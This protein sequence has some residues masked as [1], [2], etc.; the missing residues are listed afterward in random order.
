M[1]TDRVNLVFC[2][3]FQGSSSIAAITLSCLGCDTIGSARRRFPLPHEN[4][5]PNHNLANVSSQLSHGIVH[6]HSSDSDSL[7][8][9]IRVGCCGKPHDIQANAIPSALDWTLDSSPGTWVPNVHGQL[10][11][12]QLMLLIPE[13]ENWI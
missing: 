9:A 2:F 6:V 10:E 11:T 8:Q 5:V 3:A 12:T 7:A 4:L 1:A 13:I